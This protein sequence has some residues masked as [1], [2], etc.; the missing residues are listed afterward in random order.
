MT[1]DP[2]KT[3]KP[4]RIIYQPTDYT[5]QIVENCLESGLARDKTHV[6]DKALDCLV[7]KYEELKP[8]GDNK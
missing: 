1:I 6:I 2:H 8:R 4:K 7:E 5:N 3:Q